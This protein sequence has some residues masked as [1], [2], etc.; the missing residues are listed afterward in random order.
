M[1]NNI[2]ASGIDIIGNIPW[3][4]HFCQFYQTKEDLIGIVVP[5]LKAGLENNE[6]C[7]W[8]V[9]PLL[10]IEEAKEALKRDIPGFEFYLEK[11]QIEIVLYADWYV[12]D[13]VSELEES[14]E[15][16]VEKLN[17]KAASN[18]DGL[19]LSGD[20][21][22]SE[23][24]RQD[25]VQYEGEVDSLIGKHHMIALCTYSFDKCSTAGIAEI[26]TNHQFILARRERKWERIENF[27]RKRAEDAETRLR[28]AFES[29]ERKVKERTAELEE[30]YNSQM[31]NSRRLSEAQ[32]MAHIGSWDWNLITDRIYWSDEVYRIF[33]LTPDKYSLSL[34][35]VLD[36]IHPDDRSFVGNAIKRALNGEPYDIEYRIIPADGKE[37]IVHAQGEVNFDEK[38][39]P[40]RMKGTVQDITERKKT[41]AKIQMLAN[42][43][44][45]S[46]DAIITE[47]LDYII[48]SWNK[49]A[50]QVYGYSAEEILGNDISILAPH[51]LKNETRKLV[52]QVKQGE[53]IQQYETLRLGKDGRRINVSITISPV[54]DVHGELTA[55]SLIYRDITE[56]KEAGE[57]LA[58]LEKIRIKEIHHRIKNNLQ[59]I[60]S[61]LSLQAEKFS[62]AKTLEAFRE[63]QNRVTSMALIHEELYRGNR[64]DK[65][66]FSDYLQKLAED[67]FSSYNL[68]DS[69]IS[70]K[71]DLEQV[72]LD[73]DTAIPL[74]I[75]V[76]ELVS[77]SFKHAF[78]NER[79]GEICIALKK[80]ENFTVHE[81]SSGVE[82]GCR[83]ESDLQYILRVTDNGKG[84]P[85]DIDF[86]TAD[87][88][89]F[90]L[91]N[92]LVE[93]VDGCIEPGKDR[94]TE[95][96]IRFS[97]TGK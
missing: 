76:N 75:I 85:E 91:I 18:Y 6:F 50:E 51:D 92:L 45:S 40:V 34:S 15:K 95:F 71:V 96:T 88:L 72:Y 58:K 20:S 54:L 78:S 73:M 93:Q 9:S 24:H 77:N 55:I 90:Q 84:I 47:S 63:S 42:V 8:I 70:L 5:Y 94:G 12:K 53:K 25:I 57:A 30:A 67:L 83:G 3:G 74:G 31:E 81:E 16:R 29:L 43:V 17:Q 4:T 62:D 37:R 61:L 44:E 60:S 39:A 38:N 87:S 64:V 65:L 56:K 21:F 80:A 26:V 35:K 86:R 46:D 49:G 7:M 23:A 19:R 32:K 22:W 13:Y 68:R 1:K 36:N 48:T 97:N 33:G 41:E 79:E 2:R 82:P 59:V 14:L 27:G 28:E 66:D 69:G 10:E 11:G 89:G 52:E